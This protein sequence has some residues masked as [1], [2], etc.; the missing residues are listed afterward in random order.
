MI[1]HEPIGNRR[2]FDKLPGGGYAYT[3]TDDAVRVEVRHLRREFRQLHAEVDVLCDWAGASR[4]NSSLS[5]AD[6][7]LSSQTARRGLAKYCA[8]RAHTKPDDFDW[9]GLIDA[10]C[11]EVIAA[12]RAGEAPIILD[13]APDLDDRDFDV[14]GIQIPADATS[15]LIAHGDSLKSLVL[16]LVLGT[17]ALRPTPVPVLLLDW[18]W[19]PERH[20]RRK[21]RLFGRERINTLHYLRCH[22]P[23]SVEADRIRRY[24]DQHKIA[25]VGGDSV[26]FACDGKLADDD[27][28]IRSH[29][30]CANDLPPSC[31][32]PTCR[33]RRWGRMPRR[34]WAPADR[35]FSP[36]SVG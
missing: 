10:T 31:G 27:T 28:A 16:L 9:M 36:I 7:N 34:G 25:F 26:A 15:M 20:R 22:A 21:D 3:M 1:G 33:S 11:I 23:L 18:E 32:P 19:T 35:F 5:R 6:L 29:R 4:H 13:D 2:A 17:L 30:V 8:E 24:C 12:D 14:Q